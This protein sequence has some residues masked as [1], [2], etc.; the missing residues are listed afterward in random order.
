MGIKFYTSAVQKKLI[1]LHISDEEIIISV[2]RISTSLP[3]RQLNGF[4]LNVSERK[5]RMSAEG[6]H[7]SSMIFYNKLLD[8]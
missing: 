2:K 4:V 6:V 5:Y 7:S 1:S 3:I 8:S